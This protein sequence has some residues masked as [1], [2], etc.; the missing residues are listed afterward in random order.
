MNELNIGDNMNKLCGIYLIRNVINN[1]IYVGQSVNIKKRW[2]NHKMLLRNNKHSSI[3]LQRAW[4]LYGE[5][6]FDFQVIYLCDKVLLIDAEQ[7][8][9]DL[10]IPEYNLCKIAGSTAGFRLTNTTKQKISFSQKGKTKSLHMRE[11]LKQTWAIRKD[12]LLAARKPITE[13]TRQK[14]SDKRR[15]EKHHFFGVKGKNNPNFGKKR[16]PEECERISK[17]HKGEVK[18]EEHKNKISKSLLGIPLS[19]ERKAQMKE[20]WKKS[21]YKQTPEQIAKRMAATK[22][23]KEAKKLLLKQEKTE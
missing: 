1:H 4:T 9:M 15:G 22:A 20:G 18:S 16:T 6:S 7:Y 13:E 5:S 17:L 2:I 11:A 19:E 8:W 21:N 3:H 12:E 14:M 10:L 23:T